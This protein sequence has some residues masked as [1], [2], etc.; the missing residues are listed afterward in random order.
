MTQNQ[1]TP[2]AQEAQEIQEAKTQETQAQNTQNL[3][4][5]NKSAQYNDAQNKQGFFAMLGSNVVFIAFILAI[6]VGFT[7]TNETDEINILIP[8]CLLWATLWIAGLREIFSINIAKK[9]AINEAITKKGSILHWFGRRRFLSWLIY[10]V[11]T[12]L[13]AFGLSFML[14]FPFAHK[15]E[16]LF[17]ALCVVFGIIVVQPFFTEKLKNQYSE[18]I[19]PFYAKYWSASFL[20]FSGILLLIVVKFIFG[21][22][23]EPTLLAHFEK[24]QGEYGIT[25]FS[26][27][28]REILDFIVAKVAIVEYYFLGKDSLPMAIEQESLRT[29][30]KYLVLFFVSVGECGAFF[31]FA[32]LSLR[33]NR[34]ALS[35]DFSKT[36][37]KTASKIISLLLVIIVYVA[38]NSDKPEVNA[39]QQYAQTTTRILLEKWQTTIARIN[40]EIVILPEQQVKEA[41]NTALQG[42][43]FEALQDRLDKK[44][45]ALID[46]YVSADTQEIIAE[47]YTEWHFSWTR[48]G[49]QVAEATKKFYSWAKEKLGLEKPLTD[50][51]KEQIKDRDTQEFD[52]LFAK[53]LPFDEAFDNKIKDTLQTAYNSEITTISKEF[54]SRLHNEIE[55]IVAT[56]RLQGDDVENAKTRF[57]PTIN[58]DTIIDRLDFDSA[59]PIDTFVM[60]VAGTLIVSATA[61]MGVRGG[62]LVIEKIAGKQVVKRAG[63]AA[64]CGGLAVAT[65][66]TLGAVC[67]V[68]LVVATEVLGHWIDKKLN[69]EKFK[70]KIKRNLDTLKNDVQKELANKNTEMINA[71]KTQLSYSA[72]TTPQEKILSEHIDAEITPPPNDSQMQDETFATEADITESI[73]TE[74]SEQSAQEAQHSAES[75]E[76]NQEASIHP[77]EIPNED[78]SALESSKDSNADFVAES[79]AD[80]SV[81]PASKTDEQSSAQPNETNAQ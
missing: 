28:M 43:D 42:I 6:W 2:N 14:S 49:V 55:K 16:M 24:L 67:G 70:Q 26:G 77:N 38:V 47:T 68:G 80:S 56:N 7:R 59:R 1:N 51:E 57:V 76:Q 72:N 39:E 36:P 9:L 22:Q 46:S 3:S 11:I 15:Y 12:C 40:N 19:A 65:A 50:E 29:L 8:F 79:S 5:P 30:I 45:N 31:L 25:Q 69:K 74:S 20:A 78:S 71:L 4:T 64:V 53:Y 58:I 62:A 32:L 21:T 13:L 35:V 33:V 27:C 41:Y 61:R 66:G 34:N 48:K 10:A 75:S 60:G 17:F 37:K 52:K 44:T 18:A 81:E 73:K 23:A 54:G 63:G